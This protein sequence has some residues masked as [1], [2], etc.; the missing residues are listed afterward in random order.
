MN[1][2][3]EV[4]GWT[5]IH[6]VWQGTLLAFGTAVALGLCRRSAAEARY[7]IACLGLTAMLAT[8]A[9]TAVAGTIRDRAPFA[10]SLAASADPSGSPIE[11][12][13]AARGLAAAAPNQPGFASDPGRL[14]PIVVWVWLAGVTSLLAVVL[15]LW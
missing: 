6:F 15:A 13:I 11:T 10:G 4:T 9:A 7:V 5:L 12:S 3:I 2:W 8:A 1:P 14:L